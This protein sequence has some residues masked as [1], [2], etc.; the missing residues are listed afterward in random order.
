[1]LIQIMERKMGRQ[2][3]VFE[4]LNFEHDYFL[5]EKK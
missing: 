1:M 4:I 2:K 3:L 5:K